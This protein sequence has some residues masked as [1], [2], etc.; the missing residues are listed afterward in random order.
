MISPIIFAKE[1]YASLTAYEK[2]SLQIALI[3]TLATRLI[4][5]IASLLHPPVAIEVDTYRY[6]AIANEPGFSRW[7]DLNDPAGY[8]ILLKL[9][10]STLTAYGGILI[11]QALLSTATIGMLF[12]IGRILLRERWNRGM[13]IIAALSTLSM[14][15]S[16]QV[17]TETSFCFFFIL[18]T[19]IV[20][21]FV[22]KKH[23]RI[24]LFIGGLSLSFATLIRPSSMVT[25]VFLGPLLLF[26]VYAKE[27]SLLNAVSFILGSLLLVGLYGL[28]LKI[29]YN[30]FG[31]SVKG[32]T[33]LSIYYGI[34]IMQSAGFTDKAIDSTINALPVAERYLD[35]SRPDHIDG[36][37]FAHQHNALFLQLF[38]E[39]PLDVLKV[40]FLGIA[41]MLAWPPAGL[42][43][44]SKHF[45]ALPA[46]ASLKEM[47]FQ[48]IFGP[49]VKLKFGSVYAILH[50]RLGSTPTIIL[51]I[52]IVSTLGWIILLPLALAGLVLLTIDTF[53][54][55]LPFQ[56]ALFIAVILSYIFLIPHVAAG[57]R[58]RMPIEPLLIFCAV[59]ALQRIAARFNSH[60]SLSL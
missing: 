1:W 15:F 7:F 5:V 10:G 20:L 36:E 9:T 31:V 4:F 44:L 37:T 41:Q 8:P 34:P 56:F 13:V 59:F 27:I 60:R 45:G 57:A 52:W 40:H 6:L 18:A 35:Q 25:I 38:K 48:N 14:F 32:P 55:R 22:G 28:G 50:E 30:Y 3:L 51:V 2:R 58:F 53:K 17:M 42:F 47:E 24:I 54:E 12:V 21:K 16:S 23:R 11:L 46:N 19:V 43:Q 33:T 49:L 39:H 26:Y 29:K